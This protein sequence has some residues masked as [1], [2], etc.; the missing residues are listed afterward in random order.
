[1]PFLSKKKSLLSTHSSASDSSSI[2]GSLKSLKKCFAKF[3]EK[4]DYMRR[5]NKKNPSQP[6][7]PPCSVSFCLG[8][9]F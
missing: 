4:K 2:A 1:M 3:D 9:K 6:R 5:C 8:K 7:S